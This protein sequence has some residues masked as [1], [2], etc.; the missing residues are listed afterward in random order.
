MQ[1][2]LKKKGLY[3]VG[4][5][6]NETELTSMA[7]EAEKLK[8]RRVGIP[9]KK[10]KEHGFADEWLANTDG[11]S[12]YLKYCHDYYLKTEAERLE[13]LATIARK[14]QELAAEKLKI[15]R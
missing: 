13:K 1:G 6:L 7:A 11:V 12:R 15:V 5:Y 9:I 8:F 4:V 14:E 2:K 3:R 10:Q